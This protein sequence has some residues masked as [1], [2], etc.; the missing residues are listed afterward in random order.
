VYLAADM[1]DTRSAAVPSAW[2]VVNYL[3]EHYYGKSQVYTKQ[4]TLT[5]LQTKLNGYASLS[6]VS[7]NLMTKTQIMDELRKKIGCPSGKIANFDAIPASE[8]GDMSA[9]DAKTFTI[10][11]AG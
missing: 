10:V 11:Y 9:V 2:V 6:W 5:E 3:S 8:R 1:S 4:E 7:D